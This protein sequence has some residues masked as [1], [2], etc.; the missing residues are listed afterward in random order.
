MGD[1]NLTVY[2]VARNASGVDFTTNKVAAT[3]AN[4]YY[5]PGND[6]NV[7]LIVGLTAASGN[8]IAETPNTVDG[9]AIADLTLALTQNKTV[10]IGPFPPNVY[11][12]SQGRVKITVSANTDI[13]AFR[14]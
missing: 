12:D 7:K 14:G 5:I 6:G 4:N 13:M 11:N 8:L 2:Q 10:V 1:V 9:Q 3:S